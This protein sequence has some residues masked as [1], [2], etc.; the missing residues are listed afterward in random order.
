MVD[1]NTKLLGSDADYQ[2]YE[3][4]V[5]GYFSKGG[6]K[7]VTVF[8]VVYNQ[9]VGN[10][11]P[12]LERSILGGGT[13]LEATEGIASWTEVQSLSILKNVFGSTAG[14]SLT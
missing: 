4:E 1:V 12:F 13:L 14:A 2:Q 9:T 5:K 6:A 3:M 7:R 10:N 11:V 8:R